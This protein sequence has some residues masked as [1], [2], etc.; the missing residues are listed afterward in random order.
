MTVCP[1]SHFLVCIHS[2]NLRPR[3]QFS[4]GRGRKIDFGFATATTVF[5]G[6]PSE[7][8]VLTPPYQPNN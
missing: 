5:T 3:Y 1:L 6:G 4:M 8:C 7:S 2:L